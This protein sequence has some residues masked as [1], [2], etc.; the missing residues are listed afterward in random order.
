MR[1]KTLIGITV[2]I[3]TIKI[4]TIISITIRVRK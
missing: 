2:I 4:A 3:I 1:T